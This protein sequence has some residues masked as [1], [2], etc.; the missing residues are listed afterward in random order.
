MAAGK[1]VTNAVKRQ[2]FKPLDEPKAN[3][4]IIVFLIVILPRAGEGFLPL[5]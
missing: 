1:D 5:P 2:A 3:Q 4:G